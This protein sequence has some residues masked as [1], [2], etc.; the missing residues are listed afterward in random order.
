M[1]CRKRTTV[2]LAEKTVVGR[3]HSCNK[4]ACERGLKKQHKRLVFFCGFRVCVFRK[5]HRL[6]ALSRKNPPRM[7]PLHA[8]DFFFLRNEK[9][10][11]KKSEFGNSGTDGLTREKFIRFPPRFRYCFCPIMKL[12]FSS[13]S[14]VRV[15]PSSGEFSM[16]NRA[17]R[18]S[19]CP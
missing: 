17:S 4:Y 6:S 19:I 11:M 5:L 8:G 13:A 14:T 3:S 2:L 18:D 15:E 10:G 7:P 9:S 16:M 12:P 1:Q